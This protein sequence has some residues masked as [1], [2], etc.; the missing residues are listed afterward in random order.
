MTLNCEKC[1]QK[2]IIIFNDHPFCSEH[3]LDYMISQPIEVAKKQPMSE[4]NV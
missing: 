3:Y 2:A 1:G 4:K